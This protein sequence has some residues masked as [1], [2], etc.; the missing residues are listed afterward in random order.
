MSEK[1][2]LTIILALFLVLGGIY[3]LKTPV[4]EASDELWH[5]PMVRHLADGNP[6]PVQVFDPAQAGPW[7]QEASQPPLYYYLGAALT[8]WIDTSDMAQV[9]RLNPHVDNGLITE[10][11]NIN[12]V[13]HD[14]MANPWQGTLLAVRVVRLFS[15]LLGAVTVYLTFRIAKEALPNRPDVA[16]GATAVTAF[17]PMFLFISGAV[18]NDNLIVPLAGLALWLMVRLVRS[19]VVGAHDRGQLVLL[20]VV[21][22]LAALTKIS[23]VGLLALAW[24]TAVLRRWQREK[25]PSAW[26][27]LFVVVG[28]GTVDWLLILLPALAVAG[29]WYYRNVVLYGDWKGWNAFIAVLGQRAHPASLA[30]LWGERWGFMMSYWGLFGGVNVPMPLWI[31]RVLNSVVVVGVVGFLVFLGR[32]VQGWRWRERPFPAQIL[33]LVERYF[34][35]VLSLLWALAI[36]Y[37]LINWARVTWS[38]QGRLVFSALPALNTLLAVGLVGWLPQRVGR[39]VMAGLGLFLLGVAA[40]APFLWI[41]PAY[42]LPLADDVKLAQ[43]LDVVFGERMRLRGFELSDLAVLPGDSLEVQLAWE[44]VAPM[45]RDWS[46]FVHLN[47]PVLERPIAQRDMYPGQGLWAT[48]LMQPGERVVDRYVLH[49]PETAVAPAN[50]ELVVGLYDFATGERLLLAD[51]RDAVRLADVQL[52]AVPGAYPNPVQVNFEDELVLVGFEVLPR[53]VAAG[54]SVT[55]TLYWQVKR[56]L[57]ADYTFFAQVVDEDTTRWAAQD[58]APTEG[59]SAWQV[60]EVYPFTMTLALQADTPPDIYPIIIG[61]YTRTPDGGFDRLQ[62]LTEDGRLT[63]D[64]LQLT[65]LR[66]E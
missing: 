35:L 32:E 30:Q 19:D 56:P 3:A 39:V 29:W 21:I 57:S 45:S 50:L 55:V 1:R 6:L 4:F 42:T 48:S 59:T 43:P 58:L 5:Y 14:P 61:L 24:G 65:L 63:D 64:F 23:G 31:Y 54:E 25:R 27:K 7:K 12:L 26:G 62:I 20:G 13:V 28:R 51:G 18:N 8:F 38:S 47:D 2:V 41:A 46:V 40:L 52:T 16:L 36:V 37:G 22:G 34:P 15:V 66:V 11:G 17:T 44:A 60:G 33:V 9:R 49:V 10:D 53:R